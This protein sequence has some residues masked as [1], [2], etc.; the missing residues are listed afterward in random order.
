MVT[1]PSYRVHKDSHRAKTKGSIIKAMLDIQHIQALSDHF[2]T[3]KMV[4]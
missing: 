2:P 4:I 1:I 3:C